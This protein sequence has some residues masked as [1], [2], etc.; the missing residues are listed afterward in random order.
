MVDESCDPIWNLEPNKVPVLPP[1]NNPLRGINLA[2]SV[3][4]KITNDRFVDFKQ[5]SSILLLFR[6]QHLLKYFDDLFEK[7]A[8]ETAPLI[9]LTNIKDGAD[10][11]EFG[12]TGAGKE[13]GPG[14]VDGQAAGD[15]AT[16]KSEPQEAIPE[17]IAAGQNGAVL[18]DGYQKPQERTQGIS[19]F[20]GTQPLT[21]KV[22]LPHSPP[23]KKA[24][25]P[26]NQQAPWYFQLSAADRKA[27]S[28]RITDPI[29]VYI[30]S[31]L[32]S[33]LSDTVTLYA[34]F[35]ETTR[36]FETL[37]RVICLVFDQLHVSVRYYVVNMLFGIVIAT[38]KHL[39]YLPPET[40]QLLKRIFTKY[41]LK[42]V[43]K[44]AGRSLSRQDK[45]QTL[46]VYVSWITSKEYF[47]VLFHDAL[48]KKTFVVPNK[49]LGLP[50]DPAEGEELPLAHPDTFTTI[51]QLILEEE[52]QGSRSN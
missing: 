49:D 11:A 52:D 44:Q 35:F 27:Y 36:C 37:D 43:G 25:S 9:G 46:K 47:E 20:T 3:L 45:I 21:T 51:F 18:A 24:V 17:S 23:T 40:M 32:K 33:A 6:T 12:F 19:E 1:F 10:H 5:L 38:K 14:Q 15:P 34:Q 2:P 48:I 29:L 31:S 50:E 4:A 22:P 16:K 42:L 13:G 41:L 39:F 7:E 26:T 8:R 28:K 30:K